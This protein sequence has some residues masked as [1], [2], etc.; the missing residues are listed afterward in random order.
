MPGVGTTTEFI[1]IR[2]G[3]EALATD[4]GEWRDFSVIYDDRNSFSGGVTLTIFGT[5]DVQALTESWSPTL[6]TRNVSLSDLKELVN[7]LLEHKAWEHR[8]IPERPFKTDGHAIHLTIRYGN[9]WTMMWETDDYQ[10]RL[11]YI[12]GFMKKV[13]LRQQVTR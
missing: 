11:S 6:P 1:K 2:K 9:D 13:A 10:P 7:L 4:R 8:E 12:G 3:L 5:G